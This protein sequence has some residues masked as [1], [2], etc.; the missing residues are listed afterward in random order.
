MNR[1]LRLTAT[2]ACVLLSGCATLYLHS[3]HLNA[4]TEV[5]GRKVTLRVL[6]FDHA[7]LDLRIFEGDQELPIMAVPDHIIA[8]NIRNT[9]AQ[10]EARLHCGPGTCRYS[11]TETRA[12]GPG[13]WLDKGR[14]HTL[15][16]VRNGQEATVTVR[17]TFKFGWFATNW[18]LLMFAPVGWVVDG[19]TGS[20]N[21]YSRL[22]ID[23][24]FR[25]AASPVGAR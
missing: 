15:R 22:D 25:Q 12:S 1:I 18:A 16:F 21:M 3:N 6:N 13:L 20:W 9:M 2:G 17:R 14:P 5:D 8:N 11:W 4:T 23:Q 19:V 10:E 7:T 24:V